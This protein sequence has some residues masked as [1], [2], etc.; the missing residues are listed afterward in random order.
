MSSKTVAKH[1]QKFHPVRSAL[2]LGNI[3]FPLAEP[4]CLDR[5]EYFGAA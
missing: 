3:P 4:G 5:E 1:K 2:V